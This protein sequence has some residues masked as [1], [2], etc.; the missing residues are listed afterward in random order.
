MT[1]LLGLLAFGAFAQTPSTTPT[2]AASRG[3]V[4]RVTYYEVKPGKA[5]DYMQ[6]RRQNA[7]PIL[8]EAKKQGVILNYFWMVQP[9]GDGPA[10]WDVAMVLVYKSYA[11]ALESDENNRKW[12]AIFLKHYG[13][14]EARA[15]SDAYQRELRDVVST[16]I[17]RE[18]ILNPLP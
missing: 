12:D 8:D 3:S 6:F 7:K 18:Q 16:H 17:M 11:D 1:M 5:A 4:F 2:P 14:A 9:T 13:S 10:A 15:K